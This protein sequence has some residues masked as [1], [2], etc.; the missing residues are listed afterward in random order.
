MFL[1]IL[2]LLLAAPIFSQSAPSPLQ[3]FF[4]QAFE[5][6]LRDSPELATGVGRHEFDDRWSDW[7]KPGRDQRRAHW[8]HRLE[9][10][11]TF[12]QASLSAQDRLSARLM[13]YNLKLQL[14]AFDLENQ[15][16]AVS[17]QNGLHNR[18]YNTIDRM[19]ARTVH[20][21]ENILARLRAV[22]AY[23]DQNLAM[24]DEAI[25]RGMT[26]PKIVV[27]LVT[28]QV[29]GQISQSRNDT[30]LLA[31]FRAF[32]NSIPADEQ[33]KLRA[34]AG[35]VYDKQFLPAWRKYREYLT[36]KYARSARATVGVSGIPDGQK[37]YATLTRLYTTTG[38]TPEEIHK[39]GLAEVDRLENEMRQVIRQAGF[40]GSIADYER[41]LESSPAQH[42][43]NKE[44]MLAYCR[45]VAKIVEPEL[46]NQ[47]RHIPQLLYGIRIIPVERE[48]STAT[49]AQA[50]S[51]DYTVPGWMN[52]NT[53][54][55]EKQVKYD[56]QALVLH[57]SVPGHIFQLTLARALTGLPAFRRFYSNSAYV[58]G[59]GLYAESLGAQLGVYRDPADHFGQLAS[60]RFRA[61]RL[62]VDTGIHS[63]GW[64]RQQAVDYF[65]TH[66]PSESL[67]EVDRYIAWPAQALSYKMGQ[68]K[69]R[70]LRAEAE[71]KLGSRFDIREFHDVVL[72]DGVLPL[73]LLQQQ[74]EEW[75]RAA[76]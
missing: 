37:A 17:Q 61:V 24:L 25:A 35:D 52:L 2:G 38:S 15:L 69:I 12:P 18:I 22:P 54:Q 21:Y 45:N 1:I 8:Q 29:D 75:L 6:E 59:W 26:Q 20:D 73:D 34:E 3:A 64:S 62:V 70:Q 36:G 56:K 4:N 41:Q 32:P 65:K 42:F 71:Q 39:L 43:H 48:A 23:I 13:E 47:F 44:E 63:M 11:R 16:F 33:T 30:R 57:E 28:A 49:N 7:S 31:A 5:E 50:P 10:L 55:P 72:R 51:P 19:P 66:A 60:E 58:E 76:R 9:N 68:L 14:E 40:S 53:Y 46:P 27:D 74:V 67:A